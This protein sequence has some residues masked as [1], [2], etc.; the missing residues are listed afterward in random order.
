MQNQPKLMT[1][2]KAAQ[3]I[4][5]DVET[6]RAW[7]VRAVD[8]LPSVVTSGA[9]SQRMHRKVVMAEVDEWLRRQSQREGALR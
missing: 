5:E 7:V 4:G 6:V 9:E 3:V 8:P 2:P 1:I